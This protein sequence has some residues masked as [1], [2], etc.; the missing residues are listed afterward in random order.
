MNYIKTRRTGKFYCVDVEILLSPE[1]SIREG[2]VIAQAVK[3]EIMKISNKVSNVT[4][5]KTCNQPKTKT[6][7]WLITKTEKLAFSE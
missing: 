2:D 3:S 5:I 6:N 1:I 4:I 7:K